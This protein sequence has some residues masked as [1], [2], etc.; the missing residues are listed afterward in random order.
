MSRPGPLDIRKYERVLVL[1]LVGA[2]LVLALVKALTELSATG[3]SL[4]L[5]ALAMYA[6]VGKFVED[7]ARLPD[8]NERRRL[9]KVG[10]VVTTLIV[11]IGLFGLQLSLEM[12]STFI[13]VVFLV[14]LAFNWAALRTGFWMVR[15]FPVR[16]RKP[17]R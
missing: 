16:A 6:T 17:P 7:H 8:D 9:M 14:C 12:G 1:Y 15:R 11:V 10:M 3:V 5:P 4:I 13:V 2:T